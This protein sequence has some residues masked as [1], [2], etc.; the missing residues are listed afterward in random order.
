[1]TEEA[2]IKISEELK[3]AVKEEVEKDLER[4]C[5]LWKG[6]MGRSVWGHVEKYKQKYENEIQIPDAVI[7]EKIVK[8]KLIS[9][10]AMEKAVVKVINKT[11]GKFTIEEIR[12]EMIEQIR[13]AM[14]Q[15]ESLDT[16]ATYQVVLFL[17][18]LTGFP[19][20]KGCIPVSYDDAKVWLE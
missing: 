19:T 8:F 2:R 3:K 7:K 1:V 9:L 13:G 6:I 12:D 20:P 18:Y 17:D 11:G 15:G 4:G 16:E 10:E 5:D 14:K